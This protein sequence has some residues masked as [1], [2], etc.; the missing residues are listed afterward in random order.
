MMRKSALCAIATAALCALSSCSTHKP[1]T[2]L[3]KNIKPWAENTNDT[4]DRIAL[5]NAT[6]KA[7]AGIDRDQH[8]ANLIY[9]LENAKDYEVKRFLIHELKLIGGTASIKPLSQYLRDPKLCSH[10]TQALQAVNNSVNGAGEGLISTYSAADA[11]AEALPNVYGENLIHI[12]KTIGSVKEA[13][14]ETLEALHKLTKSK[15]TV[16]KETAVRALA[17]I[18]DD[19]S[20]NTMMEAISGEKHYI[21]SKMVSLNLLYAR[22]IDP[23]EGETH[24]LNVMSKVDRTK[25]DHLYIKCLSTLQ[26]IKGND[27]NDDLISYLGDSN[28]R[29]AFATVNLLAVTNDKSIDSKLVSGLEKKSPLFQAQALKTLSLR[30]AD[31]ASFMI[32]KSL[33]SPDQYVRKTAAILSSEAEVEDVIDGLMN[34][35]L[36]GSAED[37]TY[38]LAAL[39]RIPAKDC[40]GA[41]IKA[42]RNADNATKASLLSIMAS[43][44]NPAIA[45]LALQASLTDDRNIKKEA[46]KV[47][48]NTSDFSQAPKLIAIMKNCESSSDLKGLQAGLVA[49]AFAHENDVAS[50][51]LKNIQ[52]GSSAKSNLSLIQVLSR[53]G[54]KTAFNGL[55]SLLSVGSEAVQKETV[56]TLAKWT[57]LDEFS[58]LLRITSKTEGA[59]RT[60]M[61][62]GL[63]TL[64]VNGNTD[65]A[66]KK[67]LLQKLSNLAPNDAEKKKILDLKTKIK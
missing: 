4:K 18:A 6:H 3:T 30:K 55:K 32:G 67:S 35:V 27:F 51:V 40:A 48:K 59:N 28:L 41:L 19:S 12:V 11:L 45:D 17:E 8:E 56:R 26:D 16:L 21:R 57:S 43:K 63:S 52:K 58:E 15:D 25:E 13:D 66:N 23:D 53:I 9:S 39:H 14:G 62:R 42:Y 46:Y 22:N 47:L 10:A 20:A 24:A 50:Q 33:H 44:R 60:L 34:L 37:K 5:R 61:V 54:G 36:K 29:I 65:T 64:V 7:A 49:S 2:A 38:G 31:K 1:D